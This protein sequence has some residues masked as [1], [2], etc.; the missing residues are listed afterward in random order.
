MTRIFSILF[1]LT[2][3]MAAC[4]CAEEGDSNPPAAITFIVQ[5]PD[6]SAPVYLTGNLDALG[7]WDPAKH[8]MQQHDGRFTTT[9]EVP[10]G[11]RIEYKFTR[12]SWE[13]E[14]LDAE[15]S[16]PPNATHVVAGAATI[17]YSVPL[18]RGPDTEIPYPD[19]ARWEDE[20]RAFEQLD[21]RARYAAN[22]IVA[23]GSSSMKG[24]HDTIAA[25]LAPLRIIPRGF[26]GSMMN[27]ALYY[28][29]RIV[30]KYKP[31]AILLYEGDND[32]AHGV[33]P[34]T[35]CGKFNEFCTKA[36]ADGAGT[37]I[38][39]LSVKPSPSRQQFWPKMQELN[40]L[41]AAECAKDERL[42]FIDTATPM[43]A[44]GGELR[45][46]LFLGDELHMNAKGYE[47]WTTAVREA[48]IEREK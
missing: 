24:W 30:L 26:G 15:G 2:L 43:F 42:T 36:W 44:P 33:L 17:E 38:Y 23:V 18:F 35:A 48:M 25:D 34:E 16:V 8:E 31:K 19:P 32:I 13:T 4:V 7:P 45:K 22:S 5:A 29:D 21:M 6:G 47:I 3:G 9:L 40:A 27:D 28:A 14:A 46:D 12:G 10:L 41:L 20:I 11:T 1:A 39:V 37:R